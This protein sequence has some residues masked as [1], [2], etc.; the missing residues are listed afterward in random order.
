MNLPN[1]LT[2]LRII[3][4][5]MF[6]SHFSHNSLTAKIIAAGIFLIASL[7]DLLDGYLAKKLNNITN[8]GKIMDPIADKFLMLSAFYIFTKI[9]LVL[10]WMFFLILIRE[11]MVTIFR[12]YAIRQGKVCAAEQ[13]GKYK[14]FLQF[15]TICSMLSFVI[16]EHTRYFSIV[17][18]SFWYIST[19]NILMILVVTLTLSSGIL[20][21]WSNRGILY[22]R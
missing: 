4:T 13:L 1:T 17:G 14:T 19:I 8:F 10:G 6:V 16:F 5:F 3:L 15:F 20:Y 7:T 22:A 11:V 2:I 18:F 9:Q 12:L 21:L